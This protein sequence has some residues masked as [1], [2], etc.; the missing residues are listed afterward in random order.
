MGASLNG[1][2]FLGGGIP[3]AQAC[4]VESLRR[5]VEWFVSYFED[6]EAGY[7]TAHGTIAAMHHLCAAIEAAYEK[8]AERNQVVEILKPAYELHSRSRFV[9]RLQTWPRG[10]P[11]DFE[12]VEWIAAARPQIRQSDPAYW[13]EWY[14]LNTAIAQQHRNKLAWQR[15]LVREASDGAKRS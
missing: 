6:A 3:T 2:P 12:T 1:A 10:Y 13:L 4:V 14:A 15:D 7:P 9:H 8:G 11:G 5:T